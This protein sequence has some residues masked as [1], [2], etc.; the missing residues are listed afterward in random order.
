MFES[1]LIEVSVSL[2]EQKELQ[3]D[4]QIDDDI[5]TSMVTDQRRV[6]QILRNLLS[7]A[8]KFTHSGKITLQVHRPVLDFRFSLESLNERERLNCIFSN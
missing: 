8:F 1:L 5:P 3:F 2:A 6:E 7:N 4:V